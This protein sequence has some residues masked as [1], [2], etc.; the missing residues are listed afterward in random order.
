MF[1]PKCGSQN[2]EGTKFCRGCGT[3]ISNV[4]AVVEGRPPAL[5]AV[6]EKHIE[7]YSGGLRGLFVGIGFFIASGVAFGVSMRL[8]V[9]GIFALFFASFFIGTGIARLIQA[10]AL[11]RL[12]TMPEP[13]ISLPA[14]EPEYLQP[15]RSIYDTDDLARIPSSVTENTTRHLKPNGEK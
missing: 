9:L 7:L 10:R 13:D 11:R 8:A 6:V 15:S 1:C 2:A 5:P 3:D 12:S 14:G 4:L